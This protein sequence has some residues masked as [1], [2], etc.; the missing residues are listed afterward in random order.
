MWVFVNPYFQPV[1]P[2]GPSSTVG[3]CGRILSA[4]WLWTSTL[5]GCLLQRKPKPHGH[6][7]SAPGLSLPEV[8]LRLLQKNVWNVHSISGFVKPTIFFLRFCRFG[9]TKTKPWRF[10]FAQ[11]ANWNLE[12]IQVMGW[13]DTRPV[14]HVT[15]RLKQRRLAGFLSLSVF[16]HICDQV[17]KTSWTFLNHF[18]HRNLD[19]TWGNE[20]QNLEETGYQL[21]VLI[22]C[23]RL[24]FIKNAKCTAL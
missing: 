2:I 22:S 21:G 4:T 11:R 8:W 6:F 14:K 18:D 3:W 20:G 19:Q 12:K 17:G 7:S 24:I 23:N 10:Q 1:L 5:L 13:L 9:A 15:V 16:G